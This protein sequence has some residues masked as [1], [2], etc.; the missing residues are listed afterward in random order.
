MSAFLLYI[1]RGGFYL[2]LFYAFFL[3]VMRRTKFYRL[4]R[5]LLLVGSYLCLLLPAFRMRTVQTAAVSVQDLA[6]IA[7]GAEP[8]ELAE[9]AAAS[10]FPWNA[11]LLA[12]YAAAHQAGVPDERIADT[13]AAYNPQNGRLQTLE[14]GGRNVLVNLAKNPTGFNQNL[15]IVEAS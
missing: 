7:T 3:L 1:V 13:I 11:V 14:V 10:A 6:V 15:S 8:A 2:G 12:L 9:S 5:I 4:N